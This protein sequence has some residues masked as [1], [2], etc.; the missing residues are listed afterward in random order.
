MNN[1][2]ILK[3][4]RMI[5]SILFSD[6]HMRNPI[7]RLLQVLCLQQMLRKGKLPNS[8]ASLTKKGV[9]WGQHPGRHC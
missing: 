9:V 6:F 7:A 3:Q 2:K 4:C 5:T 1:K 8:L